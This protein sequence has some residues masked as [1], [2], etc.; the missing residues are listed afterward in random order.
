[1]C[2]RTRSQWK[3]RLLDRAAQLFGAGRAGENDM[4][5]I[6][7]RSVSLRW[8]SPAHE[9]GIAGRKAMIDR[10]TSCLST[11]GKQ[12]AS[13]AIY[14]RPRPVGEAGLGLMRR[15]R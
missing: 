12:W 15:G 14:Y 2:T 4:K 1:M 7:L 9:G 5:V 8:S 11:P 13:A 6:T 10:D 3:T